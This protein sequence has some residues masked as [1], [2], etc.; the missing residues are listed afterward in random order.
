MIWP[1]AAVLAER[2]DDAA[3]RNLAAAALADHPTELDAQSFELGK[4]R[5]H[6]L[7]M[8]RSDCVHLRAVALRL[9][10]K[11][12]QRAY[13]GK[14]E[15]EPTRMADEGQPLGILG[16]IIAI[17]AVGAVG[18]GSPLAVPVGAG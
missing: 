18:P 1:A 12:Y 8:P 7:K 16:R 11:I 3:G 10:G 14:F 5:L 4:L 15:P 2:L 13:G 17:V 9:V 6:R